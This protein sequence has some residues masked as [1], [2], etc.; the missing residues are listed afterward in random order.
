KKDP[1]WAPPIAQFC[2][3]HLPVEA[4]AG[5]LAVFNAKTPHEQWPDSVV[6]AGIGVINYATQFPGKGLGGDH[7]PP[8]PA[9]VRANRHTCTSSSWDPDALN[10]SIAGATND[11]RVFAGIGR[12]STG[13]LHASVAPTRGLR[14]RGF[15]DFCDY[16]AVGASART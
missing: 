5:E 9:V 16:A 8:A 3:S 2:D 13:G 10:L 11:M 4:L 6:S 15:F 7:L 1:Q 14:D 12:C